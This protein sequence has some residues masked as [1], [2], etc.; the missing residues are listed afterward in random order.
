[1][2]K[3]DLLKEFETLKRKL[4]IV[5]KQ[6]DNALSKIKNNKY[7]LVKNKDKLKMLNNALNFLKNRANIIPISDLLI[8]KNTNSDL[9][10]EKELIETIINDLN[11]SLNQYISIKN[12]IENSMKTIR[13]TLEGGAKIYKFPYD[14]R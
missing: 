5:E 4:L 14:R 7:E 1:M 2:A 13:D 10:K 6:I 9:M 8:I 11:N 12:D 3:D